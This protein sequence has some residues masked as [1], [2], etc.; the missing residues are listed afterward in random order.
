METRKDK[1]SDPEQTK[2]YLE[3]G[4]FM[5]GPKALEMGIIDRVTTPDEFFTEHFKG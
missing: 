3:E 1:I 2:K 5:F 4:N